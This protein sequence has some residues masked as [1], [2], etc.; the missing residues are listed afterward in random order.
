MVFTSNL[1]LFVFLP[2]FLAVYY[3]L[4][5]RARSAWILLTSYVFYGWWRPDFALLLGGVTVGTYLLTWAM[6]S[7]RWASHRYQVLTVGVVL[8]L[9][10]LGYFKYFNFGMDTL[11]AL[12]I[13]AGG[14]PLGFARVLLPIGLSFFVFHAISYMV[15]VYRRDAPMA[16]NPFDFAAF[17]SF[18]PQLV[19]GPVLRYEPLSDQ[20]RYR[21]HSWERFSKGSLIFMAGFCAKVLVADPMS[22]LV[23]AAF[24]L[25]Q[26]SMADAWLGAGAYT[27]QL[28]FD[29]SG[30]STMAVGLGL[31][32]GFEFPKNFHDPYTSASIT[33]FWR[34][35]HMS[36][37]TWL[38]VYLY[39]P[40][41]GNRKGPR[42][43]YVNLLLTMLLGG[44][45]HGANWTF[46]VWGAWHGGIL[47]L[48]RRWRES[49]PNPI[50]PRGVA[51]AFTLL[52]VMIG[53][54]FFR[55]ADMAAALRMLGAMAGLGELALS[56]ALAWQVAPERVGMM[57]LG[58]LL[59]FAMPRMRALFEGRLRRP[60]VVVLIPL[61]FWA[62]ATLSSQAFT[63]FLYFQ[64]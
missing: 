42:R 17:I 48:E 46:I 5:F 43:T 59:V 39:V 49:H 61:F 9:A 25:H 41:G 54:V 58:T 64:F 50:L 38:R 10:T 44:L 21:V 45:W 2:A 26:P 19:A 37:S 4:P 1:F 55:A 53:W 6:E 57:A 15:D 23:E 60:M 30:Y 29:F 12:V 8:N 27:V 24:S 52:L 62:V 22:P 33:E 16:R 34:R 36:L 51:V 31:M 3:L 40:L 13:A 32:I 11:N 63:P 20:F 35:W 7:A 28:F 14:A 18:F 47:A 56:P